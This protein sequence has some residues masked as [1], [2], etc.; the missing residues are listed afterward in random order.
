MRWVTR[1]LAAVVAERGVPG[2]VLDPDHLVNDEL[3]AEL[4]VVCTARDYLSL[5]DAWESHG[6]QA[7]STA[8][9]V[10][11]VQSAE[12]S[13][14]RAL[15]WD[16]QRG[17]VVATVRWPVDS[18]WRAVADQLAPDLSDLLVDLAATSRNQSAVMSDLLRDGY[19]IVL[20]VPDEGPELDTV[21]RLVASDLVP[22]PMWSFVRRLVHG[23][24]AL[25]LS[26]PTQDYE[27]L[28]QAWDEWLSL[29]DRAQNVAVLTGARAGIAWLLASGMLRPTPAAAEGLPSWTRVGSS[30]PGPAETLESI[31]DNP[32][33]PWL[34]HS[35][36]DWVATASWWGDVRA[37]S[38][39][40]SPTRS[41][42][43]ERAWARWAE[44]DSAFQLWLRSDY[45]LLFSSSRQHPVT[46]NQVA[47]FLARRR[48]TTGRRQLLILMDGLAFAQWSVLR[49]ALAIAVVDAAGCFA[50][51]PTLTSVSRQAALAGALPADFA[52]SL[53]TTSREPA[54]WRAFWA[55]EGLSGR[56]VGYHL[57]SG[58]TSADV[59]DLGTAQAAA[60]V[61]LAVDEIM[62]G[63]HLLGD[64]QMNA[65]LDAWVRHGFLD[66]L[67][68]S[69]HQDGFDVWV[70][71]DHGNIEATPS[72]RVMERPLVDIA[73]TRVRLYEN[74]VLR[75][76][77]RAEGVPWD[78]PALPPGRVPL[79]A[80]GRSGYHSGGLKVSHGGLS[81]D[82]VI[83]PFTRVVPR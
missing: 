42:L 57:T 64:A 34:P 14:P 38:A 81:L 22:A 2:V 82:E 29:G 60:V 6:R 16:I 74:T 1:Q 3:A 48:A 50:L 30:E 51:C 11:L 31:L 63:S 83:V 18:E 77:A 10:F 73:G 53:W 8:R 46:L 78:P 61:V 13:D 4:E 76:N 39:A 21:V 68:K 44:I 71:A 36:I 33:A 52:D 43:T 69:A 54:R 20:P 23:P 75:D 9:P 25:A 32:P 56:R 49:R 55:G 19:G 62:H 12:F 28:Q 26:Q 47:P 67:I 7:D 41:D 58:A 35:V 27:P 80:S 40:A 37:A 66:T 59:P 79:F 70:T 65:S 72:G 45:P 5:R 15:P 24:L 17:S